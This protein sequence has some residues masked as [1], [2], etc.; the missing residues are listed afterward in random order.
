M[1][2]NTVIKHKM[3]GYN[4]ECVMHSYNTKYTAKYAI[5]KLNFKIYSNKLLRNSLEICFD[6]A[7][8]VC[9][10]RL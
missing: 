5:L 7:K 1:Q 2:Q 4:K 10:D 9:C 3:L 6:I 8:N